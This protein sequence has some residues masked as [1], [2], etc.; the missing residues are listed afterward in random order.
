MTSLTGVSSVDTSHE[1]VEAVIMSAVA[2]VETMGDHGRHEPVE[3]GSKTHFTVDV[4]TL[5]H[6]CSNNYLLIIIICIFKILSI[7][8]S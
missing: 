4:S 1:L 8:S 2:G 5:L 3:Q 6:H 7:I